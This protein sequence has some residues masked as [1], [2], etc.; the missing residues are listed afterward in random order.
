MINTLFSSTNPVAAAATPEVPTPVV[1]GAGSVDLKDAEQ[2]ARLLLE[3]EEA[4]KRAQEEIGGLQHYRKRVEDDEAS[5][6]QQAADKANTALESLV[7]H[8]ADN[9]SA[10]YAES[11]R[12]TLQSQIDA[13]PD[14]AYGSIMQTKQILVNASKAQADAN[15]RVAEAQE[16]AA[17]VASEAR[18]AEYEA[19]RRA[20]ASGHGF[21]TPV[22][23]AG[24]PPASALGAVGSGQLA[25]SMASRFAAPS[26]TS[27]DQAPAAGTSALAHPAAPA[28]TQQQLAAAPAAPVGYGD[29]V[30]QFVEGSKVVEVRA[31]MEA[32]RKRK[33]GWAREAFVTTTRALA[34][35]G[36]ERAPTY[37]ETGL[38]VVM[39][40]SGE[41]RANA[42]GKRE[43][44]VKAEPSFSTPQRFGM[45]DFAPTFFDRAMQRLQGRTFAILD[46]DDA[47]Q[48]L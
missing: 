46:G 20:L 33:R 25:A 45:Q 15:R 39:R 21:D 42:Q 8:L 14:A 5:K 3:T 38:G 41:T 24:A 36:V 17:R 11:Q 13:N 7:Q 29:E 44:V 31:S 27:D 23:L 16:Q 2:T 47:Q 10:E 43:H 12:A 35:E 19:R 1:P 9:Y 40:I 32:N 34:E 26:S 48:R 22:P 28:A 18:F 37:N 6:R 4:L 30:R